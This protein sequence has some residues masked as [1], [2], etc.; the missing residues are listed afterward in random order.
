MPGSPSGETST[1]QTAS[2]SKVLL[3]GSSIIAAKPSISTRASCKR[4]ASASSNP[5]SSTTWFKKRIV[6]WRWRSP[7]DLKPRGRR[8]GWLLLR[9]WAQTSAKAKS[10][11]YLHPTKESDLAKTNS[12]MVQVQRLF[13]R[14]ISTR[15]L[16]WKRVVFGI[17][18]LMAHQPALHNSTNQIQTKPL[19]TL[20]TRTS[21]RNCSL[22]GWLL[23]ILF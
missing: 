23:I 2:P 12:S 6:G 4:P 13:V 1:L 14:R 20:R 5:Y 21:R 11:D 9:S 18:S 7:R 8:G 16:R 15:R 10:E 22:K 17:L 3:S 19:A